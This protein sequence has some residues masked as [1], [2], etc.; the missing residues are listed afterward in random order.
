MLSLR[1]TGECVCMYRLKKKGR[2]VLSCPG[3]GGEGV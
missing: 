3:G 1:G 2:P